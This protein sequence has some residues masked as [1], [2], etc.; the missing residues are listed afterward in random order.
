MATE[1]TGNPRGR[2]M[3]GQEKPRTLRIK[4][5]AVRAAYKRLR[6]ADKVAHVI[7]DLRKTD[8]IERCER[9]YETAK[10]I[11]AR[12]RSRRAL[13]NLAKPPRDC[14][15]LETARL[16]HDPLFNTDPV[17]ALKAYGL[18]SASRPSKAIQAFNK[19]MW[20]DEAGRIAQ[21]AV[22]FARNTGISLR[23]AIADGIF[24]SAESGQFIR[25]GGVPVTFERAIRVVYAT[26]KA[27]PKRGAARGDTGRKL[28]VKPAAP[29]AIVRQPDRGMR[30]LAQEGEWVADNA[31]WRRRL[32]AGAV[33]QVP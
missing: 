8:F 9:W 22:S 13:F 29:G 30:P 2:P 23:Y 6:D 19:E 17:G 25:N 14:S 12:R 7:A 31:F 18:A 24:R 28:F 10:E 33:V 5:P 4:D 1:R 16:T 11:D 3:K 20:G 27:D 32:A 15:I 26:M 21:Y